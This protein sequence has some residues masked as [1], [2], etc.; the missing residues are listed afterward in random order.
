MS[1][2]ELHHSG[3]KGMKWGIRRYQNKDGSLTPLG[4]KRYG[5]YPKDESKETG[6][7]DDYK[8]AHSKVSV[9]TMSDKDLNDRINRLQKE[10]QYAELTSSPTKMTKGRSAVT[11]AVAK[12]GASL[13]TA[14]ATKAAQGL[15]KTALN[16][17]ADSS[18]GARKTLETL[19][20]VDKK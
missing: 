17:I 4:K 13:L 15:T 16:K 7:H 3:I 18:D 12:I 14:Y 9:N 6:V 1:N 20:W 11:K 2:V 19:T 10:K 8:R 5:E